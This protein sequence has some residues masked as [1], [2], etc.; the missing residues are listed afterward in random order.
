VGPRRIQLHR[1]KGWRLPPNATVVSRPSRWGNPWVVGSTVDGR[2]L[3]RTEAAAR[4]EAALRAG[5]LAFTVEDVQ[6][7]LGGRDLAC[8]CALDLACH[9]DVLLAIANDGPA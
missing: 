5:E 9:A 3:E 4:Y 8:W 6:A 7:A 1:T 2:P